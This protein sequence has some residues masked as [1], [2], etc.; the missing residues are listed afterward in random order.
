MSILIHD[1][2]LDS[3]SAAE[4]ITQLNHE[5]EERYPEPGAN[6]FRLDPAEVV[7][8]RGAFLIAREAGVA[9]G[10]GAYREIEPGVAEVKRMYVSP[11]A[12]GRGVGTALLAALESR[13]LL[14]GATRFVLETGQ[15]QLEAVA[16]YERAGYR[17][18]APF[19]EYVTSPLSLCMAKTAPPRR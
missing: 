14:N 4:L 16:L 19:G 3:P 9:L 5:L 17:R 8:G 15:R 13:A 12:R 6:H 18:V 2:P 1:E 11:A 10:C 7:A